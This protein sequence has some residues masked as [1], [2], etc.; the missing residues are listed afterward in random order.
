MPPRVAAKIAGL[1]DRKVS[2]WANQQVAQP[3][4]VQEV[5]GARGQTNQRPVRLY[6]YTELMSLLVAAELRGRNISLQHIRKVVRHLRARGYGRPLTDVRFAIAGAELYFQHPDGTWEGGLRPDQIV[7]HEVLNLEPLRARILEGI[8]RRAELVA[9]VERRRGTLGSKPVFAGTR[10]PVETVRRYL[11]AG[12]TPEQ[13]V[14]AFPVLTLDDV[15][16]VV[17]H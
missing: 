11:A 12:R 13:I 1:T 4:V 6:D 5:R 10:V 3:T 8:Q 16:A 15:L 7:I 17:Q 9:E 2:Y 14:S